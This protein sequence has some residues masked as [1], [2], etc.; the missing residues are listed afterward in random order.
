MEFVIYSMVFYG[1]TQNFEVGNELD[2]RM[3]AS[4]LCDESR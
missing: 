2:C 4:A 3:T 1:V